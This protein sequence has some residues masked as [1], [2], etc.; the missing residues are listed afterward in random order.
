[1]LM[2]ALSVPR[3]AEQ[4]FARSPPLLPAGGQ[5]AERCP[6]LAAPASAKTH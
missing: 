5:F 1:M 4:T 6:P 2:L 3:P